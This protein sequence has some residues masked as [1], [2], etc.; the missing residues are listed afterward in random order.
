MKTITLDWQH[1]KT[2]LAPRS[3]HSHKGDY[4]HSLLIG[5][6]NIYQCPTGNPAMASGGMGDLLT[7]VITGLIAQGLSLT[8]A[9]QVG[10]YIH[11]KA[12]DL[13]AIKGQ[14]GLSAT[15]LIPYLQQLV[16][17]NVTTN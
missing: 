2:F 6:N 10:V 13:A 14:R 4:G 1:L 17:P 8:L 7:G 5:G 3:E 16:N 11:G 9:A 15:E 12:G